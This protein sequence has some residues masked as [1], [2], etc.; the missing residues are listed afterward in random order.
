MMRNEKF[1]EQ[2]FGN[3]LGA[4]VESLESTFKYID[5][6][7]LS[8]SNGEDNTHWYNVEHADE[9]LKN[10]VEQ[11]RDVANRLNVLREYTQYP[12]IDVQ[13]RIDARIAAVKERARHRKLDAE[14]L[15]AKE[16][17]AAAINGRR[18]TVIDTFIEQGSRNIQVLTLDSV[19]LIV[20]ALRILG[21][22]DTFLEVALDRD[23]L[24]LRT[25]DAEVQD[26]ILDEWIKVAESHGIRAYNDGE[27]GIF[28][29]TNKTER[30]GE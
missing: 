12:G 30:D 1:D 18:I 24:H 3:Q 9:A 26:M 17:E 6:V 7:S 16:S 29:V 25:A 11:L 14:A 13:E 2:A 8:I 4:H 28:R 20:T 15:A 23:R 22:M 10:T 21:R 5:R 27:T 19:H